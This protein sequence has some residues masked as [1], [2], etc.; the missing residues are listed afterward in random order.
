MHNVKFIRRRF[1][2]KGNTIIGIL[3]ILAITAVGMGIAFLM[4][5]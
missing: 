2:N 3:A 5:F 1:P 4:L